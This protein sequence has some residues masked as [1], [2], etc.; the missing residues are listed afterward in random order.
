MTMFAGPLSMFEAIVLGIVEGLTEFLPVSSTGHL[1]VVQSLLG[2]D[3]GAA[4]TAADTFSVAIQLGAILAVVVL[5]RRRI[6]QMASGLVGRDPA[7]AAIATR[8]ATAFLPAAVAGALLGDR[9]KEALFGPLPVAAAWAVGG[10]VLLTWQVRG[11][12]R[13]IESLSLVSVLM[14][15]LAQTLAL[16]PGVS[17][18]LV[19]LLAALALGLSLAAALEFSFLL[20]LVT[21][22]AASIYDLLRN[23]GELVDQFG[24]TTP[25]VGGV[26][27]MV[28]AMVSVRWLVGFVS[29]RGLRPFGWY[30]IAAATVTLVLVAAGAF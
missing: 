27:G 23:G 19:T 8:V 13:S 15:G 10:V 18:S 5:Y 21:L 1:L 12:E 16:W 20:G 24:V 28:T 7:G 26:V 25:I 3:S 6:L 29:R 9:I 4:A 30:R 2:I 11:G 14:I 22:A 17:R